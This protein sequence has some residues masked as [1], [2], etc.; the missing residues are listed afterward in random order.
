MVS[1]QSSPHVA[2]KPGPSSS[3]DTRTGDLIETTLQVTDSLGQQ[4]TDD[5]I[6][7]TQAGPSHSNPTDLIP[8]NPQVGPD[9]AMP[10][11]AT[12]NQ[13]GPSHSKPTNLI[14]PNPQVG[15]DPANPVELEETLQ[16]ICDLFSHGTLLKFLEDMT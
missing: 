14:P 8:P 11:S 9:P 13:A 15:P 2:P 16:T 1:T 3:A 5:S 12:D 7:D 4:D 6:C 10:D